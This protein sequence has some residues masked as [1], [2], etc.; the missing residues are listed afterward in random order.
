LLCKSDCIL[1][2]YNVMRSSKERGA[3]STRALIISAE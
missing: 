2:K 3:N 1:K